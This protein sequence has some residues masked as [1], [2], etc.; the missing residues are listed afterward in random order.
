[1]MTIINQSSIIIVILVVFI[2]LLSDQVVQCDMTVLFWCGFSWCGLGASKYTLPNYL[3][4]EFTKDQCPVNCFFTGDKNRAA[5][6]DAIMFEAQPMSIYGHEYLKPDKLPKLPPKEVGQTF[7]HFGYEHEDYFPFMDEPTFMWS[8][9][10][11]MT[12][13]QNCQVPTTFACSWGQLANGSI[14]NFLNPPMPFLQKVPAAAF[15]AVNCG[16]GGAVFRNIYI[17]EMM[18][19]TPI[20]CLG[21][22]MHN[23]DLPPDDNPGPVWNDLG[24]AMNRKVHIFGRYRFSLAFENNNLTDYISEK[25]FTALLSGTL[26]IYMGAPNI[27]EF[28]PQ[29]SIIKTSDFKSPKHLCDYINYLMNNETEYQ[30]YFEWKKLPLP[31]HFI[32]K[33]DRCVFYSGDCALCKYL[34]KLKDMQANV[35]SAQLQGHRF[36]FGEP[37]WVAHST[38]NLV[39]NRKTCIRLLPVSP[40]QVEGNFA[41]TAWI[42]IE[43]TGARK[44]FK[45][46]ND[47]YIAIH[48]QHDGPISSRSSQQQQDQQQQAFQP[49]NMFLSF[50]VHNDCIISETPL[51]YGL[52][53][54]IGITVKQINDHMEE[55]K[56]YIHGNLDTT[57]VASQNT[58]F[59]LDNMEIGCDQQESF[60]GKM[61]DIV[62]WTKELDEREIRKSMYKKY[63]GNED[64]L[65]LYMT[66]NNIAT[67]VEDYSS[68]RIDLVDPVAES[69]ESALRDLDLRCC[70]WSD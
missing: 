29:N 39:V 53:R 17:Q 23:M 30:K 69:E 61:D 15:L 33:Y 19:Y 65:S 36:V 21:S 63:R 62:I 58:F 1:M 46:G 68:N 32:D 34:H 31:A 35:T 26:P 41:F 51:K 3:G 24:R 16:A 52:W 47:S 9:D 6:V 13:R 54:H 55:T 14:N 27:D 37:E 70:N 38:R 5:E 67:P 40:K 60:F 42:N 59:K 8:M 4:Q 7:I 25:V 43:S 28:V 64:G 11:N 45:I 2:V 44:V 48:K 57:Q 12:F 20:H 49:N 10:L 22:C 50:C 56:L 18:K 66:F